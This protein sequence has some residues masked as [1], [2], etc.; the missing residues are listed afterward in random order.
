MRVVFLILVLI[1]LLAV[2]VFTFIIQ[3]LPKGALLPAPLVKFQEGGELQGYWKLEQFFQEDQTG[4]LKLIRWSVPGAT[5][6][7]FLFEG[8]HICTDGQLDINNNPLRCMN[9]T[10]FTLDGNTISVDQPGKSPLKAAWTLTNDTLTLSVTEAGQK[11]GK[12]VL[13]R[14]QKK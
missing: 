9:Y 2:G 14:L 8:N 13:R 7:Y 5:D 3:A 12:F 10:T 11:K 1:I 4:Q 6:N